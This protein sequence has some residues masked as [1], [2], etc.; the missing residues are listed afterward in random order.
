MLRGSPLKSKFNITRDRITHIKTESYLEALNKEDGKKGDGS[1]PALLIID[2]YH[3]HPTTEFYDLGLGANT[4]EELLMII[5]TAGMD[6]TY[7][8]YGQ[9]YLYC[10]RVLNP[11][12]D[13]WNDEYFVGI[14]EIDEKDD[15][16]NKRN[17]KKANPIRMTYS[18]GV[19]KIEGEY[20]IAKDIPEKM[21]TFLTKCLNKWVQAKQNGY[22]NMAKWK[23][24][25]VKKITY[26]LKGKDVFVG[27]DMS[28][29]VDLTSVA[30]IIPIF[31]KNEKKQ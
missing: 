3:Q 9:E 26:D 28:A 2:E 18:K 29:K 17:W 6:L 31:D 19:E 1:N 30:F 8:C 15:I 14:Q 23:A 20:K 5:T 22:M 21:I 7:P 25:E 13:T 16:D 11:N 10:S 24:C 12:V 27:F 4:K